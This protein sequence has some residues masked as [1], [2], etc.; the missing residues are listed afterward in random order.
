M[1]YIKINITSKKTTEFR[2]NIQIEKIFA[3]HVSD[4][5]VISNIFKEL[6]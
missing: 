4:T 1:D 6:K 3:I 2:N 5:G